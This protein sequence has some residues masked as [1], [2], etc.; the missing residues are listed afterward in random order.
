MMAAKTRILPLVSARR[1]ESTEGPGMELREG[2]QQ[3][4]AA[5]WMVAGRAERDSTMASPPTLA[6][7]D[8]SGDEDFASGVGAEV[9]GH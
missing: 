4:R 6:M 3:W 9:G 5:E 2:S 1:S 7:Y 8:G